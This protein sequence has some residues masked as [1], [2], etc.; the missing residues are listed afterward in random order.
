[1]TTSGGELDAAVR[2]QIFSAVVHGS[3]IFSRAGLDEAETL[4]RILP[5]LL[6]SAAITAARSGV[7]RKE[8]E[9]LSG[10]WYDRAVDMLFE[11]RGTIQ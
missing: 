10:L 4:G 7:S 3:L 11:R 5:M 9:E 6:W 2:H 8:F 1:M